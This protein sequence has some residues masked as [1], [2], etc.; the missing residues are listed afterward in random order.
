MVEIQETGD[1]YIISPLGLVPKP[2]GGFPRIHHLSTPPGHSV[3]DH[4]PSHYGQLK[5]ALFDEALDHVRRAGK[6][7]VMVKR[8]LADAFRHIPIHPSDWW[9]FGFEWQGKLFEE[10][11]L[12]FGLRT[13]PR[14]FN[15]F[16]EGLHWSLATRST[17]AIT[18]YL[19]DFLAICPAT[20]EGAA[21]QFKQTFTGICHA[22]GLEIKLAK[23]A[24]GMVVEFLGLTIDTCQMEARI[25]A[26]KKTRGLS[27]IKD[28]AAKKSCTLW[29]LQRVTGFLN[30][31][32]KVVPLGR[33]F[34]RRLYDLECKF[35]PAPAKT[36]SAVFR[37]QRERTSS[38][39]RTCYH[40]TA[41]SS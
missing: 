32:A 37:L 39:G 36:R 9:L 17:A 30:F 35:P 24:S 2:S 7:A 16:A 33:T 14:I 38:G 41:V 10:R 29:D 20:D 15:Y 22:L 27:L 1:N 26:D 5:Y 13:A 6:G 25:P 12:P 3:N 28:L 21:L 11:F 40:T 34:C 23:N 18:H 4:I 31:I 19:G 8:D